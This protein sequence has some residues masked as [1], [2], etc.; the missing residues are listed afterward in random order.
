VSS[1]ANETPGSNQG[2]SWGGSIG[3]EV[4]ISLVGIW[5]HLSSFCAGEILYVSSLFL[6]SSY[7]FYFFFSIVG[8]HMGLSYLLVSLKFSGMI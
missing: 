4:L 3:S 7:S 5:Q 2:R 8:F 6:F 1:N